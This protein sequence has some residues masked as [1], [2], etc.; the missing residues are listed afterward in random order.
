MRPKNKVPSAALRLHCFLIF[1]WLLSFVLHLLLLPFAFTG[2]PFLLHFPLPFSRLLFFSYCCSVVSS[3]SC[4]CCWLL[5][6]HLFFF[7]LYIYD[8]DGPASDPTRISN[9]HY[10][11]DGHFCPLFLSF[12]CCPIRIASSDVYVNITA[13][14][15]SAAT[16]PTEKND[17]CIIII[18]SSYLFF[19]GNAFNGAILFGRGHPQI[20][21]KM[22]MRGK[23]DAKFPFSSFV[24]FL[25]SFR[26]HLFSM[27]R[28]RRRPSTGFIGGVECIEDGRHLQ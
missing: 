11:V 22:S 4:C 1:L 7:L 23:C 5:F 19:P 10:V 26:P 27:K 12:S 2:N 21:I 28:Q 9:G 16:F 18:P 17:A 25:F 13:L 24:S 3:T 15:T 8:G 14:D 6:L 20:R